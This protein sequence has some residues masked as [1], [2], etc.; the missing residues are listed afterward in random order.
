MDD[1]SVSFERAAAFYDGTRVT[2]PERLTTSVDLLDRTLPAGLVLEIGVGTGALAVLLAE[3]GRSVTGV[4]LSAGMLDRVSE[5]AGGE[6]VRL[7]VADATRLPFVD[8]M[9]AGAYCRWVLH[10]VRDWRTAVAELCR[11]SQRSI[12]VSR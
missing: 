2:D 10:L 4:D 9:F 5:K 11:V 6:R 8:E 7:A 1:P 3:R 12:H